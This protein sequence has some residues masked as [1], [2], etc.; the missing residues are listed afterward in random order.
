[1]AHFVQAQLI[2]SGAAKK[3]EGEEGPRGS[4]EE[5]GSPA[6][7]S[8]V[9]E[10]KMSTEEDDSEDGERVVWVEDDKEEEEEDIG[11]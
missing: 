10:D 1:M 3:G 6:S 2:A 9:A 8:R 4:T 5:E 11:D 7:P